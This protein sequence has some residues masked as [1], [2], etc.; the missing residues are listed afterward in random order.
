M[1]LDERLK[2]TL[3]NVLRIKAKR[4][5]DLEDYLHDAVLTQIE[6]GFDIEKNMGY[7]YNVVKHRVYWGYGKKE[8]RDYIPWT[9]ALTNTVKQSHNDIN[10]SIDIRRAVALLPIQQRNFVHDYYYSGFTLVEIAERYGCKKSWVHIVLRQGLQTLAR[11]LRG[12][13]PNSNERKIS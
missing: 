13:R 10:V 2:L 4:P 12:Y 5:D 1:T 11:T 9:D 8:A 3:K 7:I 6:R